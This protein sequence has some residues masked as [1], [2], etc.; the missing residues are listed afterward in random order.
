MKGKR[1]TSQ[2]QSRNQ[3]RR[4]TYASMAVDKETG[5]KMS[6]Y[7]TKTGRDADPRPARPRHS[8]VCPKCGK[9]EN[10]SPHF[11]TCP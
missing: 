4:A 6:R 10:G 7:A 11:V 1:T 8:F 2:Q 9:R 3:R 5:Q